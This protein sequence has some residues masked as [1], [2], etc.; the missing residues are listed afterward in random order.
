MAPSF[1]VRAGKMAV[2]RHQKRATLANAEQESNTTPARV[3]KHR[4]CP[5]HW[6]TVTPSPNPAVAQKQ[7]ADTQ[8]IKHNEKKKPQRAERRHRHR[9][10]LAAKQQQEVQPSSNKMSSNHRD[11]YMSRLVSWMRKWEPANTEPTMATDSFFLFPLSF[12]PMKKWSYLLPCNM[13][14][15]K[16]RRRAHDWAHES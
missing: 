15:S 3:P 2:K 1:T 4:P 11:Q 7:R 14:L 9:A 12:I 6:K 8:M 16:K 10:P 5:A 13:R